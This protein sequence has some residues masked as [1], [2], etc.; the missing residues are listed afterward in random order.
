MDKVSVI[1]GPFT[2]TEE[3]IGGFAL[4]QAKSKNEAIEWT[5]VFLDVA[6]DVRPRFASWARPHE[7]AK[8][9]SGHSA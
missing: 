2:E 5:K 7:R 8:R 3:L 4:I 9:A 1:D 6:G